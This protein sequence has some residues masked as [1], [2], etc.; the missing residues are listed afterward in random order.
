MDP[1]FG[2]V[3]DP[4]E[5]GGEEGVNLGGLPVVEEG[6][7][8]VPFL[9]FK[10]D[11]FWLVSWLYK[12]RRGVITSSRSG[13]DNSSFG[14]PTSIP[15]IKGSLT[16]SHRCLQ[17][18]PPSART[19]F[20][21]M[22]V[23]LMCRSASH[24][25]TEQLVLLQDNLRKGSEKGN[26]CTLMTRL[27][28]L[29]RRLAQQPGDGW[30]RLDDTVIIDDTNL[31]LSVREC[32]LFFSPGNGDAAWVDVPGIRVEETLHEILDCGE[33]IGHWACHGWYHVILVHTV[34]L[35]LMILPLF[36]MDVKEKPHTMSNSMVHDPSS[37]RSN[38]SLADSQES[39]PNPRY[40]CQC[41]GCFLL[42]RRGLLRLQN[43]RRRRGCG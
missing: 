3:A 7:L 16:N 29:R 24:S 15:S 38:T 31:R 39:E 10:L 37:D 40:L 13:R 5:D 9:F 34:V 21:Q 36:R 6:G 8:E 35:S 30:L 18:S 33:G 32:S 1:G 12:E 22:L 2:P 41:L 28:Q 14:V 4:G 42:L 43:Y 17:C 20:V 27:F 19:D 25:M 11:I 23:A 26:K